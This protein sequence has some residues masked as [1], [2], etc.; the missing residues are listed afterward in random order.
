MA[1]GD[2]KR[3]KGIRELVNNALNKASTSYKSS[4]KLLEEHKGTD[5]P[6]PGS[7]EQ[8]GVGVPNAIALGSRDII[9]NADKELA[10]KLRDIADIVESHEF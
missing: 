6:F 1:W 3:I 9:W 8:F 4:G 2:H 7:K 10:K 5:S